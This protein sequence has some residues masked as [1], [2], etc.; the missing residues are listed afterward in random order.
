[1]KTG[2]RFTLSSLAAILSALGPAPLVAGTANGTMT[3]TAIV[4][5]SC[6]VDARPMVFAPLPSEH[7]QTDARS[8]VVLACT[9]ASSYVVTM[10]DG[11]H[12][13]SGT[14]RMAD[15]AGTR[16]LAYEIYSDATRTRRWGGTAATAVSAVAPASAHV[17]L[18][19]YARLA[20]GK[21][22]AGAYNDTVTVTVAF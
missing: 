7:S 6:R 20:G 9:P 11:R 1:M 15:A 13:A 17:E 4:E 5:E 21:T 14:R 18:D 10:D 2:R 22:Q 12:G 3:V 19:A 16:F 8:S